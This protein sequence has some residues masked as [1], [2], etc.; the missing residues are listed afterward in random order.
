MRPICGAESGTCSKVPAVK[1]LLASRAKNLFYTG[2]FNV[3]RQNKFI[4]FDLQLYFYKENWS[5]KF[6]VCTSHLPYKLSQM[7]TEL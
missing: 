6:D 4:N 1:I 5:K 3:D 7:S 2:Q